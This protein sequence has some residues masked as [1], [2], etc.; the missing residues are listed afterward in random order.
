M[1]LFFNRFFHIG[2]TDRADLALPEGI[3]T[4]RGK[5]Y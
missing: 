3:L 1:V 2:R 4:S 5:Q